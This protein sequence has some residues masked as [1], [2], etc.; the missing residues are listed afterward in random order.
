[1]SI[2]PV[3]WPHNEWAHDSSSREQSQAES[4]CRRKGTEVKLCHSPDRT[5][6]WQSHVVSVPNTPQ[7]PAWTQHL[8][9]HCHLY[10][11]PAH[12]VLSAQWLSSL[13]HQLSFLTSLY[14]FSLIWPKLCLPAVWSTILL[15]LLTY[16]LDYQLSPQH[17]LLL[18]IVM[19]FPSASWLHGNLALRL[20]FPVFH[21]SYGHVTKLW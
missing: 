4:G 19:E 13:G 3:K 1:M 15:S 20:H 14:Q 7:P 12:K 2:K 16:T 6:F 8:L 10:N 21:S 5:F 9:P 18:P 11:H 17:L